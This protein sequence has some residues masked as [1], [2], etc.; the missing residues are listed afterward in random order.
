MY[1]LDRNIMPKLYRQTIGQ[2]KANF[3]RKY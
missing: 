2:I 3:Y 1:L